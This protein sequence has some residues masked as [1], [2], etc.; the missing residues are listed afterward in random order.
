M[1]KNIIQIDFN[2]VNYQWPWGACSGPCLAILNCICSRAMSASKV[3]RS[4]RNSSSLD[5]V[6]VL[7]ISALLKTVDLGLKGS[8][9][10][11]LLKLMC[12]QVIGLF[13]F[14]GFTALSDDTVEPELLVSWSSTEES[15]TQVKL[16]T[17]SVLGLCESRDWLKLSE[18]SCRL[19]WA[20]TGVEFLLIYAARK[21]QREEHNFYYY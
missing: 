20:I 13:N 12:L 4:L 14:S 11:W 10:W 2:D 18:D 7:W 6:R 21:L 9:K 5:E 15:F 19:L 16:S 1:H 3:A 8:L 17:G